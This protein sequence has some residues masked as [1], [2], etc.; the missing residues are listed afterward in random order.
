MQKPGLRLAALLS[1]AMLANVSAAYFAPATAGEVGRIIV[2]VRP[3]STGLASAPSS[4]DRAD[5]VSRRLGINLRSTRELGPN[6]S[7]IVL[8][9]DAVETTLARLQADP[10][11]EFAEIDRRR[12]ARA[13]PS[14]P[15]YAGQWYLQG[16]EIAATNFETAWDTT[17]GA[18]DTVVAVLDT[19]V[20]FDHPDLAGRVLPGYDFVSG[21]S[22]SS[23]V[24]ANDGNDWDNDA[25][26]P[27]D[28][29][30]VPES[31]SGPLLGCPVSASSWHGTKVASIAGAATNNGTG[32]AGGT[33]AGT[34]LPV[35]VLGKCGGYDSDIIAGMRWAAGLPMP[36]V[37][38]NPNPARILNLSLGSEGGCSSV[39]RNVIAELTDA[40]VIVISSAG[41][42]SGPV[43]APAN[44]PG[45][46]AVGGLRHVGSKVGYSS[47]GPEV[48]ISTA[49][50]NCPDIDMTFVCNF[51]L[52]SADNTGQ[53]LPVSSS[54]TD[55][56]NYNIGTSYSVPIVSAVA[57]LMYG[58]NDGLTPAEFIARVKSGA[59]P[60]PAPQ[61]GLPTCPSIDNV[62][63]QCNCTTSTCGA[64]IADA[65][66]AVAEALRPVAR[67][68]K[69]T[70][71]GA[72]QNVP[73]DGSGSAAARNREIS[74]YAWTGVSGN[75]VFVGATNGPVAT[76]AVPASGLVTVRLTVT[77][78]AGRTDA[79]L[80]TL[81][82]PD[83]DSDG[84]IDELDNCKLV[85]NP[86]QCD[87]DGD[88]YGN[89]C[90]GDLSNNMFTNAQD[91]AMFRAEL[92]KPSL[93]P[94]YNQ[95]DLNCNGFVNAQDTALFRTLL[96][97]PPGPSGLVP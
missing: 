32:V 7:T 12:Y 50:G 53:T 89:R 81:G 60:F 97:S 74:S 16:I 40:G 94:T 6:L 23:F 57:A 17:T 24:S 34:I 62:T 96:G 66:G 11:V 82:V 93:A 22:S 15:L 86:N 56:S 9:A 95:A 80:V 36:G 27:G 52:I 25:S 43:D 20:R 19:G 70:G 47:F 42:S 59:R 65:P 28:W 83:A 55:D 41:N 48:G 30:S 13:I 8:D 92:G 54:Y 63:G 51:S 39:Y 44:C 78:D 76:V 87:S 90:D 84:L 31:Q 49:A 2:G 64:G 10:D 69:P 61:A 26:D 73:L 58:V 46:L 68:A 77:D 3:A 75:P 71:S 29:V 45:V 1:L 67:V 33:W 4:R 38:S 37:P 5:T 79:N 14:D 35:R 91:T 18:A 88:G 85:P 72:G 21:E